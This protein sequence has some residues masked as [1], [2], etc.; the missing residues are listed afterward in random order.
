VLWS[1]GRIDAYGGAPVIATGPSWYD[2]TDQP[3]GVALWISNWA[4][5]AGYVLDYTGK[6]N[7][8]NGAPALGTAGYVSGVPQASG[9]KYVDW[10]WDPAGSGKGYVVDRW[11]QL[12][13]FGGATAPTRTG[14]RWG[15]PV[16]KRI[17]VQWTPTLKLIMLDQYGG[18]WADFNAVVGGSGT[19][20]LLWPGWDAARDFEI[21]DWT[22]GKGYVLDLYG[23]HT[24]FGGA[25]V[26][27]GFPYK[28]G[29]DCGRRHYCLDANLLI[30]WVIWDG[31][32]LIEFT[33]A[34]PPAVIPAA[35]R[36]RSRRS[37][38]PARPPAAPSRCPSAGTRPRPSPT[39][40]TRPPCRPR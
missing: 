23:G 20:V 12:Y 4:T 11:G 31:G 15:H 39:T 16:C 32:I 5:G 6:F 38:S 35:A 25:I 17:K 10:A 18:L 19:G 29:V 2:R 8:I 40:R 37:P 7:V 22:N 14:P 13:A 28:N 21:V 26:I 27:N 36:T 30:F 3:V 9:R 1:N 34:T 33:N 24:P